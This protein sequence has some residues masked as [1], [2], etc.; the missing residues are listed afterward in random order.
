M[1]DFPENDVE[2]L[3]TFHIVKPVEIISGIAK[4]LN[5]P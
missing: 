3:P 1:S 2:I 4:D 5:V